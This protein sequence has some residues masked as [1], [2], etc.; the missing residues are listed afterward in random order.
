VTAFPA[1]ARAA[2]LPDD[3]LLRD[4]GFAQVTSSIRETATCRSTRSE[5][6]VGAG[7]PRAFFRSTSRRASYRA[8]VRVPGIGVLTARRIVSER[9]RAI[10]RD[11][12]SLRSFGVQ[13]DTPPRLPCA[14]GPGARG[15]SLDPEQSGFWARRERLVPTVR[16]RRQPRTC[17]RAEHDSRRRIWLVWSVSCAVVE[18]CINPNDLSLCPRR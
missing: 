10:I 3:Y 6:R 5:G 7:A 14:Q 18:A 2:A 17:S 15:G 4:Y 11:L 13:T 9:R 16:C 1:A 12:S 8:L